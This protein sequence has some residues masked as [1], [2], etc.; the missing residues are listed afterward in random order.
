MALVDTNS[1]ISTNS[2]TVTNSFD[3]VNLTL[4]WRL[5]HIGYRL[6]SQTNTLAIGLYTNWVDIDAQFTPA[7]NTTNKVII[8]I[9]TTNGSV[10]Y[11]LIYP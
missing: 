4:S 7:A 9:V 2:F 6:Q 3:G 8:P 10:F 5:D 1:A 11:R